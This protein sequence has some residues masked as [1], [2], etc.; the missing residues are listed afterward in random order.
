MKLI[1]PSIEVLDTISPEMLKLTEKA[2]RNCYR[3]EDKTTE[4]SYISLH[5]KICDS[6]HYSTIEHQKITVKIV[7]SR[8]CMAQWT[9]HRLFNFS[10]ESQ[11]YVN[12]SKDKF[13]NEIVFIKPIE[14]DNWNN[15][16]QFK[17]TYAMNECESAYMRL[18]Q[19]DLK[20]Q[21]ARNVLNNAVKTTM[22]VTGNLRVW[23]EFLQKRTEKS[24]QDEIRYLA[25][26]LLTEFKSKIPVIFD[27]IGE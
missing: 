7:C 4:D 2:I 17:F 15:E 10:I 3:S 1:K 18:L 20:A 6:H 13:N 26:E 23:R 19:A 16:Q 5:K 12:Y 22:V 21:D 9:R 27:D 14:F 24:A 25:N 11:R 8:A